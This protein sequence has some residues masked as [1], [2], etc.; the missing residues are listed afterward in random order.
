MNEDYYPTPRNIADEVLNLLGND[1]Q[2][3]NYEQLCRMT[4]RA[5]RHD[6]P[7]RDFRGPF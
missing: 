2:S 4:T 1:K 3:G 7:N 5:G 6:T